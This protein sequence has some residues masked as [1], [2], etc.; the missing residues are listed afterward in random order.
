[1]SWL[2]IRLWRILVPGICC[3]LTLHQA[4]TDT[5]PWNLLC[6]NHVNWYWPVYKKLTQH[7]MLVLN[8]DPLINTSTMFSGCN[9]YE[10]LMK[11]KI[12]MPSL[13]CSIYIR[14][15]VSFIYINNTHSVYIWYF[16]SSFINKHILHKTHLVA[17]PFHKKSFD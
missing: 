9:S 13:Y 1:M 8:F 16:L 4:V 5:S 2:Y 15:I 12:S 17:H 6:F 11:G 14:C 10:C 3:E 7:F